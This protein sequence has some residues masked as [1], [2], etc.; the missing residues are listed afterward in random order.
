M[1]LHK[2]KEMTDPVIRDILDFL[3]LSTIKSMDLK[4]SL[5]LYREM[6]LKKYF[7]PD[8][9][10]LIGYK[11]LLDAPHLKW[12]DELWSSSY[13]IDR[14]FYYHMCAPIMVGVDPYNRPFV[15]IRTWCCGHYQVN[16][17]YQKYSDINTEWTHSSSSPYQ[18]MP[19]VHTNI[20]SDNYIKTAIRDI[21]KYGSFSTKHFPVFEFYMV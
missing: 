12:S 5:L 7:P 6:W 11:K 16:V 20:F 1:L 19:D 2:V 13:K 3:P 10:G 14:I 8:I 4:T 21:V 15:A 18:W 9:I 17:F